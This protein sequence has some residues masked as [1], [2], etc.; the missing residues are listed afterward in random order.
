MNGVEVVAARSVVVKGRWWFGC[1]VVEGRRWC[2][3]MLYIAMKITCKLRYHSHRLS[4]SLIV[5]FTQMVSCY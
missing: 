5:S 3:R 2:R 1:T 4:N